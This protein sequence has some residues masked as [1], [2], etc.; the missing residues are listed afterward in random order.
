LV[1]YSTLRSFS[2][3]YAEIATEQSN[4]GYGKKRA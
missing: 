1:W 2:D 4:A 3:D